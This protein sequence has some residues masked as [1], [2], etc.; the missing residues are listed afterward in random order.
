MQQVVY[1]KIKVYTI[2][3][4]TYIYCEMISTVNIISYRYKEERE[5]IFPYNENF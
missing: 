3:N 2:I 4:L 5:K 1:N